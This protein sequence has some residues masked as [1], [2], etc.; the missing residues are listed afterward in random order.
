MNANLCYRAL[1]Y[2]TLLLALGCQQR[3]SLPS[4]ETTAMA[5]EATTTQT[6]ST[7]PAGGNEK[8]EKATFGEGCFWCTEAVFQN[9]RGV[10]SVVSGYSGGTV[11]NP[12]YED[13]CTG[14]TGHAEVI[15]VTYDPAVISYDDLLKVFWQTHD[16][17][18]PNQQGHDH[19][20]QY[21]SAVFYHTADQRRVAEQYKSQ[22]DASKVFARPIVTEITPIKNFYPAE[23]YHQDYFNQ[24]PGN[25]YCQF[26]IR[27]KVEKFNKE[28][29]P[30]LK[31]SAAT[32]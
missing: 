12:T 25:Q 1:V 21:R 31:E 19:G 15:Q 14:R 5:A 18:T 7:N 29:K 27:P 23:K 9:L 11:E 28:F 3:A 6:P 20:T 2:T 22:L 30:L 13:V 4:L 32:K 26:V 10:K 8:L 17:T 16:P 24:N